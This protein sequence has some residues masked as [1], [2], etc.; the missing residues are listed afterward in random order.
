MDP[1]YAFEEAEVRKALRGAEQEA[2]LRDMVDGTDMRRAGLRTLRLG[3][4]VIFS[5]V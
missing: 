1:A 2:A 5:S 3:P 4:G